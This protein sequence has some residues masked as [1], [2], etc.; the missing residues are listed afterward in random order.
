MQTQP[1][2]DQ[3]LKDKALNFLQENRPKDLRRLRA[4]GQ[5]EQELSERVEACK[6]YAKNLEQSG[7]QPM[8]AWHRAVRQYLLESE[9]D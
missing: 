1:Y 2:S 6:R 4:Q 7:A 9:S 8:E 5:L 3:E